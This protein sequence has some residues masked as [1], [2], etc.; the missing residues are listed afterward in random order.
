M[1]R[2][3]FVWDQ[4]VGTTHPTGESARLP[5]G[6]RGTGIRWI[7]EKFKGKWRLEGFPTLDRL[8]SLATPTNGMAT[9]TGHR[10]AGLEGRL[11][12]HPT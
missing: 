9:S 7:Q 10:I 12:T 2:G 11:W 4:L 6:G 1:K 8:E 5:V 3:C